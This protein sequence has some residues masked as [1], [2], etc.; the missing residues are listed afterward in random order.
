MEDPATL[1]RRASQYLSTDNV[2]PA[3]AAVYRELLT[4]GPTGNPLRDFAPGLERAAVVSYAAGDLRYDKLPDDVR[5]RLR[6]LERQMS[7]ASHRWPKGLLAT[8][9]ALTE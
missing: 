3:Q 2:R 8:A 6:R 9:L 4:S 1:A 7:A 5:E